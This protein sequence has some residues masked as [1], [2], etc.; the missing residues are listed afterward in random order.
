MIVICC[1]FLGFLELPLNDQMRLLQSTW[2]EILTLTLSFRSLSGS[3]RLRFAQDFNLDEKNARE[4]GAFELYQ[5]VSHCNLF[6]F[7]SWRNCDMWVAQCQISS[8]LVTVSQQFSTLFA[9]GSE[10]LALLGVRLRNSF[11]FFFLVVAIR[12]SAQIDG[13]LNAR[14]LT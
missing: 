1:L 6:T 5:Q 7:A 12:P 2:A 14:N 8:H 11:L 13:D 3:G 4:C 9:S 10:S